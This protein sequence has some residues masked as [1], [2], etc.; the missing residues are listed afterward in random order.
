MNGSCNKP[1]F[2]LQIALATSELD[3]LIDGGPTDLDGFIHEF[4][5]FNWAGEVSREFWSRKSSPALG[6]A[7]QA[8]GSIF[9]TSAWDWLTLLNRS[10][11]THE[12][13]LSFIVGLN[14]GPKPPDI[15]CRKED[16]ALTALRFTAESPEVVERLF[17]LYFSARY[18]ELYRELFK[19]SVADF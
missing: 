18:D 13:A 14:N 5:K 19:L 1:N 8:N 11:P 12:P 10:T 17:A 2:K 16:R 6:V 7:N 3:E 4:R 9:W 15:Y